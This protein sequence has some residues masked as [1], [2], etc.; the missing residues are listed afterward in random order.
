MAD[1]IV[2]SIDEIID[3]VQIVDKISKGGNKYSMLR[4]SLEGGEVMDMMLPD[5]SSAKLL[6]QEVELKKYRSQK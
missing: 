1:T 5:F 6:K 2:T 3:E 4:L